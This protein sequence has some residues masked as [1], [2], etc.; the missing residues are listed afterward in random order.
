MYEIIKVI[1]EMGSIGITALIIFYLRYKDKLNKEREE[2]YNK[3]MNNHLQH[4]YE[5]D[6]KLAEVLEKGIE[7]VTEMKGDIRGC[8]YNKL[9]K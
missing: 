3:T 7:A 4:S 2:M 6:K 8:K 5:S 1:G 9:N